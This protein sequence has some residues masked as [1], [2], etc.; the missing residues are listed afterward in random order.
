MRKAVVFA[1]RTNT[2]E[3][4]SAN[5]KPHLAEMPYLQD[6]VKELDGLITQGK[7]LD[8]AQEVARGQFQDAVHQRQG[9]EKQGESL[10]RRVESHLKGS[11][12][13]TSDD[14]VKFGVRPRK[15]GP[16]GPRQKKPPA[17]TPPPA[18]K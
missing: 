15:S 3:L 1:K 5:L 8:L 9:L 18:V 16:R 12:G 2:W 13:F 11:F 7:S 14:L 10:R 6:I 17:V 4:L